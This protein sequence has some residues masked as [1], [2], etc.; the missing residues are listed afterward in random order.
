MDKKQIVEGCK[1]GNETARTALYNQYSGKLLSLCK[2]YVTSDDVAEDLLHDSFVIIYTS[3]GTLRDPD[4]LGSWMSSIVRNLACDYLKNESCFIYPG[5]NF[6]VEADDNSDEDTLPLPG[7]EM[8]EL[9]ESLPTKYGK[10]FRLSA[11]DG[12]SHKQIAAKLGIKEKTSSADLFRARTILKDA[13]KRYWL[14]LPAIVCVFLVEVLSRKT[15][16]DITAIIPDHEDAESTLCISSAVDSI[17]PKIHFESTP[18]VVSPK[19]AVAITTLP[20]NHIIIKDTVKSALSVLQMCDSLTTEKDSKENRISRETPNNI[21]GSNYSDNSIMYIANDKKIKLVVRVSAQSRTSNTGFGIKRIDNS[22]YSMNI[23]SKYT[24]KG[25]YETV[26]YAISHN[27][28]LYSAFPSSELKS[29]MNILKENANN[30]SAQIDNM[31]YTPR[32]ISI[33][34]MLDIPI[35]NRLSA[36]GGLDFSYV[37]K[38]RTLGMATAYTLEK[39]RIGYLGLPIGLSYNILTPKPV[40][41]SFVAGFKTEIPVYGKYTITHRLHHKTTFFRSESTKAPWLY[42]FES[43]INVEYNL[44]KN[45]YLFVQPNL[46]LRLNTNKPSN[47]NGESFVNFGLSIGLKIGL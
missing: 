38:S 35:T 46:M 32:P 26:S 20:T 15:P 6:Q 47:E 27:E 5:D 42:Y 17:T 25:I 13:I 43:G 31:F 19:R 30:N 2:R 9:I 33:G 3:I 36:T 45:N 16:I 39:N 22:L 21:F 41:L 37:S 40:G 8:M 1:C 23:N 44:H 11:L 7:S 4:K 29:Y 12:L 24:W 28:H 18:I 10:V 34:L 14:I